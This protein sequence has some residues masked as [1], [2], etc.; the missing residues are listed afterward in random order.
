[1]I[2]G[3]LAVCAGA[4]ATLADDDP[5]AEITLRMV[6][7]ADDGSRLERAV[8]RGTDATTIGADGLA[9][10]PVSDLLGG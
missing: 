1:M 7:G 2:V 5:D 10:L 3:L 6:V 4:H 9:L 8:I